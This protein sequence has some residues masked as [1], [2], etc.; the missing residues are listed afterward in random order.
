MAFP[1]EAIPDGDPLGPHH[2]HIGLVVIV[3]AALVVWDKYRHEEPLL[4]FIGALLAWFMFVF[5]WQY[6]HAAGAGF[7]FVGLV[8]VAAGLV[9]TW[10]DPDQVYHWS[11]YLAVSIGLLIALDDW[12]SHALGIWTP[13][14]AFWEEWLVYLIT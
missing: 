7:A 6:Y 9:A 11:Y 2:M 10:M 1:V 8:L 3:I 5:T 14:N 4:T 12:L 13:L